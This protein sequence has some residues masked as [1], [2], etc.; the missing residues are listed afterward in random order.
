M[1]KSYLRLPLYRNG[2]TN[3]WIITW[4][5]N[6]QIVVDLSPFCRQSP[7][8]ATNRRLCR[9]FVASFGDCRLCRQCVRGLKQRQSMPSVALRHWLPVTERGCC[10]RLR[11]MLVCP[12]MGLSRKRSDLRWVKTLVCKFCG[13]PAMH[14]DFLVYNY[15]NPLM[16]TLKPQS[17]GPLYNNSVI[18]TLAVDGCYILYSDEG[19]G[20]ARD[21]PRPIPS[22]LHQT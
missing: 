17:N 1:L 12:S 19:P 16:S 5:V 9:R 3:S 13:M 22:S 4:L 6:I 2:V 11:Y 8:P 20:R 21:R 14:A 7:K 15:F 18:G 10:F